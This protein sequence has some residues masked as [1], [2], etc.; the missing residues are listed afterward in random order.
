MSGPLV[1][2]VVCTH[3]RRAWLAETVAS[4]RQQRGVDW[5][6]LIVDDAS[7][8][9]TWSFLEGLA[10][11]EVRVLRQPARG[12]RSAARNRGLAEAR[13]ELVM[14]LDDDDHLRPG[15]LRALRAAMLR[16]PEAVA[17]VG[18]RWDW[19]F[20]TGR[21]RR[22]AHVWIPRLRPIFFELLFGWSAV[23]GQNLYR[24]TVV[25][26]LGGY[27][28]S[29]IP[30]EDR[31]LWLR[32]ARL[33]PVALVP[34]TVMSYRIHP[35]QWRPDD[36]QAIRDRVYRRA[37]RQLPRAQRRR[38][39]LVRRSAQLVSAAER[40]LDA[41]RHGEG[42]RLA[43]RAVAVAAALFTSPLMGPWVARRLATRVW[44]RLRRGR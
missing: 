43:A 44:H 7:T 38:G 8:D 42:V 32:V 10:A 23:S 41:G 29:C 35:G 40:A 19:S 4:V 15:A 5:E 26:Q 14:F 2:V 39:L 28:A 9:D 21:G 33:G 34:A 6:L 1:S 18:A 11:P 20:A 30:C 16:H 3:N 31:D 17:A 27:D 25:R 36:I 12:E 13:G 24:T 37:L 22:D